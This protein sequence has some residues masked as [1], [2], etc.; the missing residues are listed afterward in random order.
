MPSTRVLAGDLGVSRG[1]VVDAYEQLIAEGFL[2]TRRSARTIVASGLRPPPSEA[3]RPPPE[4]ARYDFRP[5]IPDVREFPRDDWSRA[6]RRAL[7]ALRDEDLGYGDARGAH[8]L[9]IALSDYLARVRGVVAAP[10]QVIICTG[11]AQGLGVAVRAL[12]T[13]GIRRIAMEDPAQP[14]VRR[15][16]SAAGMAVAPVPVDDHG[17]ITTRLAETG[18]QAVIVTPAHQFPLGGVL[19][20][21]RRHELLAWAETCRGFVIEDDYDAEYRYDGCPVGALQALAPDRV[22][23][24]GSASKTLAPALRLGWL[25]VPSTLLEAATEVKKLADLGT[26]C[27]EQLVYAEFLRSG[28]LDQ[29][30]RRMRLLYRSRRDALIEALQMR[31]SDWTIRGIAA[32]LHLVAMFPRGIDERQ[33]ARTAADHDVRLYPIGAYWQQRPKGARHGVVLGYAHLTEREIVDGV[34]AGLP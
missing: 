29:H 4:V 31:R 14:D 6:A 10:A 16:V 30:L 11:F 8:A 17:L 25:C 7:G 18:A 22:L 32:G 26:P 27:V 19:S 21:G 2:V 5:G 33:V 15:I 1:V 12:A 24:A 20:P 13:R 9:R 34:A 23:Y 28:A 3:V